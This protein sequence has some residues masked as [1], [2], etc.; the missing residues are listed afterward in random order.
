MVGATAFFALAVLMLLH[1][2]DSARLREM[3]ADLEAASAKLLREPLA[4]ACCQL[5]STASQKLWP[6]VEASSAAAWICGCW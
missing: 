6:S 4:R 2:A 3:E 5:A 1:C